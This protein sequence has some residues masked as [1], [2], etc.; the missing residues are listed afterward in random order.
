MVWNLI[1][2]CVFNEFWRRSRKCTVGYEYVWKASHIHTQ[3]KNRRVLLETLD[4]H[5]LS[6]YVVDNV[7]LSED[8][9]VLWCSFIYSKKGSPL[10]LFFSLWFSLCILVKLAGKLMSKSCIT[11]L[12]LGHTSHLITLR[13][14]PPVPILLAGIFFIPWISDHYS[15][16]FYQWASDSEILLLTNPHLYSFQCLLYLASGVLP[17]KVLYFS[18]LIIPFYSSI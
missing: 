8:W 11:P 1:I 5:S 17:C 15:K 7:E 13:S 3:N 18:F 10:S 2:K 16:W 9:M 6:M 14:H 12:R 4:N